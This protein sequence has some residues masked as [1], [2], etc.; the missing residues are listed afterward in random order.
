MFQV[1]D[2]EY[3]DINGIYLIV[4]GTK[5]DPYSDHR[6]YEDDSS[7]ALEIC[8]VLRK[9]GIPTTSRNELFPLYLFFF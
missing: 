8:L 5:R 7:L 6:F 9:L 1:G 3:W 2:D 4:A